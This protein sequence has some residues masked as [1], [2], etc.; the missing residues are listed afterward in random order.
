MLLERTSLGE[1]LDHSWSGVWH[2]SGKKAILVPSLY[3]LKSAGTSFQNH[4][5]NCMYHL[6]WK[7]GL[8][9]PNLWLK[10]ESASKQ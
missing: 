5:A 9:N 4:I 3:G 7:L 8:T 1:R 6:G 10:E 2:C